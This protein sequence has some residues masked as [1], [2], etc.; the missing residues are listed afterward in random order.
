MIVSLRSKILASACVLAVSA[1]AAPAFAAGFDGV[2]SGD[3]ANL[4]ANGGGGSANSWGGSASGIFGFSQNWAAEFDGGYHHISDSGFDVNA[5]NID[6]SAMYR[7]AWGRVGGVVGYNSSDLGGGLGDLNVTNYGGFVDWYAAAHFTV[8]AK[9]G[10]YNA[11]HGLDGDYAG[12]QVIGYVMPDFSITGAYDY[13]RLNHAGNENDWSIQAEWLVSETTPV[14]IY[15]GYTNT[16]LSG[17]GP[18]INVWGGGVKFYF[19]Q[20]GPSTLVDRQRSGAS[21]YGTAFG[22]TVLKIGL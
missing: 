15:A 14:S 7:G 22:P 4:S 3:Y 13:T 19:D 9:V 10:G 17:G 11:S 1:F 12:V 21:T 18:T 16:K 6:G 20:P 2:L 5:W 8:S